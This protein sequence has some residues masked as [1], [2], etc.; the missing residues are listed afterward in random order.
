[1]GE[2]EWDERREWG[3]VMLKGKGKRTMVWNAELPV[4]DDDDYSYLC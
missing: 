1:M 4:N 2:I 3:W